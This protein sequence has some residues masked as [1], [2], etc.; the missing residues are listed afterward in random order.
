MGELYWTKVCAQ[1]KSHFVLPQSFFASWFSQYFKLYILYSLVNERAELA[2]AVISKERGMLVFWCM[3]W[4]STELR[5]RAFQ[6]VM[7]DLNNVV[8]YKSKQ[9]LCTFSQRSPCLPVGTLVWIR[10]CQ[11]CPFLG[12]H[13]GQ[14]LR[15]QKS[16]FYCVCL[17]TIVSEPSGNSE[18]QFLSL[19]C[20]FD[21]VFDCISLKTWFVCL[22]DR[23]ME[24][25][26][27][28]KKQW[29]TLYVLV[30]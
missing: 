21:K 19:M 6:V 16:S 15:C 29:D 28:L 8:S 7:L 26:N 3:A 22:W 10:W 13:P 9:L 25:K 20:L 14:G 4:H 2:P 1:E 30:F 24:G 18:K 27:L 11:P 17:M 5:A 23:L 12:S